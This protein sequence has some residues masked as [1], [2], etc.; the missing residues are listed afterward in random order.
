MTANEAYLALREEAINSQPKLLTGLHDD[1]VFANATTLTL[2]EVE[3]FK[4]I[5]VDHSYKARVEVV[6]Q[7]NNLLY[8]LMANHTFRIYVSSRLASR[9]QFQ[10]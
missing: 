8:K 10:I 4:L 2:D 5:Y 3:L 1:D 9:E 6:A 7:G